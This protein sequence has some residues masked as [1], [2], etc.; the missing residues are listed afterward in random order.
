[1][2]GIHKWQT[3]QR[4]MCKTQTQQTCHTAIF[5]DFRLAFSLYICL[6]IGRNGV[7]DQHLYMPFNTAKTLAMTLQK[8]LKGSEC[9]VDQEIMTMHEVQDSKSSSAVEAE[10]TGK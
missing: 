9:T 6:M 2:E 1:M 10:S 3:G 7:V 8:A 4:E 5:N